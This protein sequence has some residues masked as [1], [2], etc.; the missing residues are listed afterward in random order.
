MNR[1][2]VCGGIAVHSD[3]ARV[4]R[5]RGY[6]NAVVAEA[7]VAFIEAYLEKDTLDLAAE[8]ANR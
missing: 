2:R 3:A 6:G 5:L 1:C 8:P 7:A 4:G